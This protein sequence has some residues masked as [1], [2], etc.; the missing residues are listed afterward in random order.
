MTAFNDLPL[1]LLPGI[2]QNV[3]KPK[4]LASFC[5]VNKIF[6]EFT[7][8][9][10]YHT[11]A[12]FPWHHKEKIIRLFRTLSSSP[13]L[14]KHVRKLEIRDFPKGLDSDHLDGL[15]DS[16]LRGITNT[17]NLRSCTWTRDRSVRR[18]KLIMPSPPVIWILP[19]W[20][21]SLVHPLQ[22]LSIVCKSSSAVTD[23]LLEQISGDLSG[24]DELHL[25]G[26]QRVTHEGLTKALHHN[27]N[28]IKSLSI[29][30]ISPLL[31]L[32]EFDRQCQEVQ[33]LNRLASL[34]ITVNVLLWN[35]TWVKDIPS[36]V[37]SSPLEYFQLY[38][39]TVIKDQEARLDDFVAALISVHGPHLRRFSLHRLPI[40]LKALDDVCT[41]FTNLEQLFIV[42]EQEDLVNTR[43]TICQSILIGQEFAGNSLS[44]ATRLQAVHINFITTR[45]EGPDFSYI[46]TK[47]ALHIVNQCGST[48]TQI[49]C[50]NRVWQVVRGVTQVGEDKITIVELEPYDRPEVPDQFRVVQI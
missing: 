44:K 2:A 12:I 50:A 26:C 16:C 33:L 5:L 38:G 3:V 48:V 39:T 1:E 36:L 46:S 45:V 41:G 28:G 42:V 7:R 9:F 31:N 11:I 29:E 14:A 15:I 13:E 30:S 8:P 32:T 43:P 23:A 37:S 21:K 35:S 22:S 19:A 20:L 27:K 34:T 6:C 17:V 47:D 4:S 49:G 24:L 25:T 10:L 18:I 40:S